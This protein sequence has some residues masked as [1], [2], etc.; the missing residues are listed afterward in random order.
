VIS[1]TF[2]GSRYG[3][4]AKV[5]AAWKA[6]PPNAN[7]AVVLGPLE[8]ATTTIRTDAVL[9]R[10][11]A[12]PGVTQVAATSSAPFVDNPYPVRIILE[13][14][15]A[16][17]LA[18][19]SRQ[20]VTDDYFST[21]GMN[22]LK[23][24]GF[25]QTDTDG[26]SVA[27][28]SL[29]FERRFFP[30]GALNRRFTLGPPFARSAPYEIVGV[31][32]DVKRQEPTD[33]IRP[34]YYIYDRRGGTP[35]HFVMRTSGDPSV[36]LPA[37]RLAVG[38]VSP[39]L[40]ITSATTLASSVDRSMVDERFRATLSAIFSVAALTLA[41]VGLYGLAARRVVDRRREFAVRVALGATPADVR[42]LVVRDAVTIVSVGFAVGL[43]ASLA[44]ARITESLL[45]GVSATSPHVFA[46]T[47]ALL[48]IVVITA[49][50]LPARRAGRLN[51]MVALKE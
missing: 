28:V 7:P 17:E 20:I 25:E 42:S 9:A 33:D 35:N 37:A 5:Q 27:I 21:M 43:P 13:H 30:E 11:G 1:T 4:P 45:C 8:R 51:P 26:P 32:P 39:Q 10:L 23:G 3:D 44:V 6:A 48:G 41:A 15:P 16:T 47:T 46:L 49:T 12:T 22:V 31:V 2:N 34:A 50:M 29:E 18:D 24:R 14:R 19:A 36:L 38:D 40:V